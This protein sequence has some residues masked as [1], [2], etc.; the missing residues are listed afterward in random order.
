MRLHVSDL[1]PGQLL[2]CDTFNQSGVQLMPAGSLLSDSDINKLKLHGIDYVDIAES[3]QPPVFP[4]P[5]FT[6]S[7]AESLMK[8]VPI[9]DTTMAGT[10]TIFKQAMNSGT[11]AMNEVDDLL[12]PM[13]EHLVDQKDVVSL[14]LLLDRDDEYTYN[15]SVQVGIL[16]Y[17]IA[18]WLGYSADDCYTISKAGYLIDIG[19]SV[20][21]QH[22]LHKPGK[23]SAEEF[24]IMKKHAKQGYDIILESTGSELLALPALQHHER[25]D[26]SGY[27]YGLR[28]DDIH[29]YSRIAAVADVYSAMTSNRV[30]QS[31]Q[32]YISVLCELYGLSFG[33][34]NAEVT[35]SFIKH[36]LPN[37][38]GK[39]VLL[40]SGDT[41]MIV[42]NN[43]NDY[44]RPLVKC[45]RGF[46]DLAKQRD[47]AIVEI[48]I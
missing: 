15:H 27:P 39:R 20:V 18:S 22:L 24:R 47:I 41:G 14:L 48:Y 46:I 43:P 6:S 37:F 5:V 42:M 36:L 8:L 28:K 16:T 35:Q 38:I 44:F 33:Q 29:P 4:T 34:L 9:F 31:K 40:T 19:K 12:Q 2:E 1:K 26:G 45:S 7:P 25:E 32:E 13:T 23:L 21:P 10:A 17:Y 3:M 11:I 30:Y